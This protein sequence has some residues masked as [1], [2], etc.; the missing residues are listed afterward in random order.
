MQKP[1]IRSLL[2]VLGFLLGACRK[3]V[4]G[5]V[6][7][8]S[9]AKLVVHCF[10]SPD[11]PYLTASVSRSRSV[12]ANQS[13]AD[14]LVRDATVTLSDGVNAIRLPYDT[15]WQAYVYMM[16]HTPNDSFPIKSET[17]YALRVTTPRGEVVTASC[18]VPA[19]LDVPITIY[20]DSVWDAYYQQ[21]YYRMRMSWPDPPGQDNLYRVAGWSEEKISSSSMVVPPARWEAAAEISDQGL[22]GRQLMS[23]WGVMQR[24]ST[25]PTLGVTIYARLLHTDPHYYRYHRS[26]YLAKQSQAN[27]FAEP[28]LIYS[29]ITGG[30]GAFGAYTET[31]T[32]VRVK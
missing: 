12:F 9:D 32:S 4:E 8:E 26:V 29:N 13:P 16:R 24:Y 21:Y 20:P 23:P 18:A 6:L 19:A 17:T 2:Q 31:T 1:A 7:P 25:D 15:S 10:I 27:P 11:D 30:L 14:T 5:F 3:E 22:D 28:V